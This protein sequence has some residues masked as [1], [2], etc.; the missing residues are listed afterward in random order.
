M[1]NTPA[2]ANKLSPLVITLI[3]ACGV[4][5][6]VVVAITFLFIGQNA[7]KGSPAAVPA[8]ESQSASP[9]PSTSESSAPQPA[10]NSPSPKPVDNSTRFT[11][12]NASPTAICTQDGE[13]PKIIVSWKSVNAVSAW[14]APYNGDASNGNGYAAALSGNQDSVTTND[15]EYDCHHRDSQEYT[16]TLVG[17]KGE[18]V[19]KH[20]TVTEKDE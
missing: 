7:G 10:E 14:F 11:A 4:L 15:H 3:A 20:W 16:I 6:L 12:F 9:L 18:K 19:S 2:P 8:A 17:P 1:S 13:H 5:L